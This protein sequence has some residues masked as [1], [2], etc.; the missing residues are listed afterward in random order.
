MIE[1]LFYL[2]IHYTAECLSVLSLLV[3]RDKMINLTQIFDWER[4]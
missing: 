1:K 4:S 3:H 2:K